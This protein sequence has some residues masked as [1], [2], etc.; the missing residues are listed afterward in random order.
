M[1][2]GRLKWDEDGKKYYRTG[3]RRGVLYPQASDGSYNSGVAWNGLTAVN[4]NPS[5]G[6]T[7]T[8]YANDDKYLDLISRETYGCTIE[9]YD[10][11]DEFN[12]CDGSKELAPGVYAG[13]QS[14]KAFGF[15]FR[16]AI[17]ND[18]DGAEHA[19]ELVIVYGCR[20]QPSS[21][22]HSTINE[23]PE[24]QTLS[25]E[26]K[27]TPVEMPATSGA[28][29]SATIRI[30]SRKFTDTTKAG[31]LATLEDI[32]YGTDG[33]TD[34]AVAPTVARLPMPAEVISILTTGTYSAG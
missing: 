9:A 29:K 28:S 31:Y 3:V 21:R 26:V 34:P 24:A 11:P 14:R 12:E 5:G 1:A 18:T 7:T 33:S 6:E 30:D 8:L 4:E 22:S 32:L 10:S 13:Q 15:T 17:G 2:A 20:A 27:A 16:N 23:S 19:Y 25:W